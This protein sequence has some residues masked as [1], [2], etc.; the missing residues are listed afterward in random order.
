MED[1]EGLG[2]V[3][4]TAREGRGGNAG[5]DK[6]R[7]LV[8]SLTPYVITAALYHRTRGIPSGYPHH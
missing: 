5:F 4:R 8:L 6:I 3:P 1:V 2:R 7:T